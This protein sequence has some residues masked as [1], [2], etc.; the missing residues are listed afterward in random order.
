M[1]KILQKS[2]LFLHMAKSL[3]LSKLV[4]IKTKKLH[5]SYILK[6]QK[7]KDVVISL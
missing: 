5:L 3:K 6:M 7:K 2:V 4:F 1:K